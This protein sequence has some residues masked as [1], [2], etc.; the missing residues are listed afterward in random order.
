MIKLKRIDEN[1]ILINGEVKKITAE[2]RGR[3]E[4][5]WIDDTYLFKNILT[6][7]S[8]EGLAEILINNIAKNV[9]I[10]CVPYTLAECECNGSIVR[11]VLTKSY[12]LNQPNNFVEVSGKTLAEAYA[13]YVFDNLKGI[14]INIQNTSEFY[15]SAIAT[16]FPK[17][18]LSKIK[19]IELDLLKIALFDYIVCQKD[20]HF[21]NISFAKTGNEISVLPLYDNSSAYFLNYGS[22]KL[23]NVFENIKRSKQISRFC[24]GTFSTMVPMLG[25]STPTSEITSGNN[26]EDINFNSNINNSKKLSIFETEL[27]IK[28]QESP[29]LN[30]FY[31]KLKSINLD[32]VFTEIEQECDMPDD[33]KVWIKNLTKHKTYRLDNILTANKVQE[34]Q[35]LKVSQP[36]LAD[37]L[38]GKGM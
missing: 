17:T 6:D 37:L 21:Y 15:V 24:Y 26:N 3:R 16:L 4:K 20:R 22:K 36:Y 10:P 13:N 33:I 19:K 5:F 2:F 18:S 34:N 11:G 25:I 27:A 7:A 14:K 28:I 35:I 8:Y 38:S 31:H 23:Q 30:E 29:K 1:H 12:R 32:K 9:G